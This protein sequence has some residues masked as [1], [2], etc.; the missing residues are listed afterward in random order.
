MK[1]ANVLSANLYSRGK[2]KVNCVRTCKD[3]T[4]LN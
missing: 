3:E 4:K 2:I 1:R